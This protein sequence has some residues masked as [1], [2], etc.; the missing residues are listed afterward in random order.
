MQWNGS[1]G[2][3]QV[4]RNKVK[5]GIKLKL[6]TTGRFLVMIYGFYTLLMVMFYTSNLRS[7]LIMKEYEAKIESFDDVMTRG[8]DGKTIY[9]ADV[10][11]TK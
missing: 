2:T 5:Q 8:K 4:G 7:I 9:I 1:T 6:I 11:T 3:L 10:Y